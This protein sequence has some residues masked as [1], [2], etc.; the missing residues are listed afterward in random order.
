[1]KAIP[2]KRFG[3][4]VLIAQKK[5]RRGSKKRDIVVKYSEKENVINHWRNGSNKEIARAQKYAVVSS[6][7]LERSVIIV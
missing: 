3:Q 7:F 2:A 6:L 5:K 1:M 4:T